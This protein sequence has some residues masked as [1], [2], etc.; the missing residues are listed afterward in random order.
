MTASMHDFEQRIEIL[1][2]ELK[3]GEE[4]AC[5]NLDRTLIEGPQ[6][7][8]YPARYW[9]REIASLRGALAALQE[10]RA[11]IASRL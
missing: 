1:T 5:L 3:R 7:G 11:R 2:A 9:A 10:S 4:V 6:E 8:G